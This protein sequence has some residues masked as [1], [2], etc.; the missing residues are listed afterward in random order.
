MN[1]P[2]LAQ[3][4]R[5]KLNADRLINL[6]ELVEI[7]EGWF[8]SMPS[9]EA[10]MAAMKEYR[11]PHAPVLSLEEAVEH[12]HLRARGTVRRVHDRIL[13]DF[14]VPGFALRFSEFPGCL[15]LHA[16]MLGEHNEE[17]LTNYLGYAPARVDELTARGIVR[18]GPA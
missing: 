11:V 5:F 1:R 14:D 12:P 16:P 7:I 8:E 17:V 13:G 9:D 4:P 6:K 18:K 15:E 10:S 3:D 2:E